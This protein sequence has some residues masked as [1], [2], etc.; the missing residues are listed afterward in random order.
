MKSWQKKTVVFL[1][2]FTKENLESAWGY[3]YERHQDPN[4]PM[5]NDEFMN[6]CEFK[7]IQITDKYISIILENEW[8]MGGTMDYGL[9]PYT[10][11]LNGEIIQLKDLYKKS[12]ADIKKMV[13]KSVRD[14]VNNLEDK[15]SMLD[16]IDW[17]LLDKVDSFNYFIKDGIPHVTFQ[18]YEIAA[19]A[20]GAFEIP[21][22]KP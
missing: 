10:F 21:L 4:D 22:P 11:D 2:I 16:L 12:D 7:D 19:G 9:V 17:D 20:A 15:D 6:I 8:F 18:K 5:I 3:E 13:E 14:Y 1:Q